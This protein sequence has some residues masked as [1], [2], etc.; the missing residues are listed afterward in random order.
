MAGEAW[1]S[2]GTRGALWVGT[3]CVLAATSEKLALRGPGEGTR[4][5]PACILTAACEP[6]IVS[7][8]KC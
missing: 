3:A 6:I 5:L 1:L 7:K 8:W 4:D 2:G